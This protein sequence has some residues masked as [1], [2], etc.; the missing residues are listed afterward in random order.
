VPIHV[1]EERGFRAD[2]QPIVITREF[3][4]T[5][6]ARKLVDFAHG[7]VDEGV[8]RDFHFP[9]FGNYEILDS[10]QVSLRMKIAFAYCPSLDAFAILRHRAG[11]RA[12]NPIT[13][14]AEY[15]TYPLVEAFEKFGNGIEKAARKGI[16]SDPWHAQRDTKEMAG[17]HHVRGYSA[18]RPNIKLPTQADRGDS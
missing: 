17:G 3:Q 9:A 10:I 11:R 8:P 16:F 6:L 4:T 14:F 15:D 13:I 7:R 12:C 18:S 1:N 5:D 2:T